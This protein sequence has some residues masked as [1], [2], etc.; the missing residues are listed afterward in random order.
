MQISRQCTV[1]IPIGFYRFVT[2]RL[3]RPVVRRE[4]PWPRYLILVLLRL[5]RT[6][7]ATFSVSSLLTDELT[8]PFPGLLS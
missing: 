2:Q 7:R 8:F 5:W 6:Q 3:Y 4:L 1:A